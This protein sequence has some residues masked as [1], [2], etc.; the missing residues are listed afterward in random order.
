MTDIT[1]NVTPTAGEAAALKIAEFTFAQMLTGD[2]LKLNVETGIGSAAAVM[3]LGRDEVT[4]LMGDLDTIT[5]KLAEAM[6]R[7]RS[8]FVAELVT[9]YSEDELVYMSGL[10]ENP[11]YVSMMQ[12]MPMFLQAV[13]QIMQRVMVK[14]FPAPR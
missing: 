2:M 3:G 7:E 8:T 1:I 13:H 5:K 10:Y 4:E 12:K 14:V 6:L 11:F 9:I